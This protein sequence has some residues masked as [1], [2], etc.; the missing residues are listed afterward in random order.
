MPGRQ[1]VQQGKRAGGTSAGASVGASVR[2][3]VG[4]TVEASVGATAGTSVETQSA[5]G[6]T[7]G[8]ISDLQVGSTSLMISRGE[9]RGGAV[10]ILGKCLVTIVV[11]NSCIW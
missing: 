5:I 3:S 10:K 8:G 11:P 1:R 7:G 9:E 4:A 6:G 2:A